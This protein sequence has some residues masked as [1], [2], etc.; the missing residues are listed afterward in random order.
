MAAAA[1][2]KNR[3][4]AIVT[5]QYSLDRIFLSNT[6]TSRHQQNRGYGIL[7]LCAQFSHGLVN[8]AMGQIPCSAERISCCWNDTDISN[9]GDRLYRYNSMYVPIS[10]VSTLWAC[11]VAM[12][13][14]C[15]YEGRQFLSQY[16]RATGEFLT[17]TPSLVVITCE[18][19]HKW[20]IA[21]TRFFELHFCR[22]M[23]R[24]IFNHVYAMRPGSY[25]VRWNSTK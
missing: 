8:S 24:C 17:L 13:S 18:Y 4:I 3:K 23:Y 5:F 12:H 15:S 6:C 11:T 10:T 16:D 9:I 25:R 19:R 20:Y 7:L 2:L 1:I 22:R 14:I 21:K